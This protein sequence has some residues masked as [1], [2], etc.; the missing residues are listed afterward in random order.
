MPAHNYLI[1]VS[2]KKLFYV[3]PF[4]SLHRLITPFESTR[5]KQALITYLRTPLVRSRN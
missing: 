2:R 1:Y 5:Q 3:P 4:R